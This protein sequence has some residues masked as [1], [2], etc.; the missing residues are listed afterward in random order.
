ML[1]HSKMKRSQALKAAVASATVTLCASPVWAS[2]DGGGVTLDLDNS[3]F[4]QLAIFIAVYL[5]LKRLV[6]V[7]YLASLD[8]RAAKTTD[9]A[10]DAKAIKARAEALQ[11]RYK[12]GTVDAAA[13][14]QAERQALRVDGMAQKEAAIAQ[15]REKTNA[16]GQ[17]ARADIESQIGTARAALLGQVDDLSQLVVE[18]VMGRGA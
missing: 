18:K 9:A 15:A 2:G 11:A 6:F 7:P 12:T 8:A 1:P 14:A 5:V 16:E 13:R 4:I 17:Q 3:L 10:A